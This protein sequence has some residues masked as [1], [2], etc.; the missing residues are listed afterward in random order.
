MTNI[1]KV[2]EIVSKYVCMDAVVGMDA[3]R[4]LV[5]FCCKKMAEWKDEQHCDE[6]T[7]LK[8]KVDN[9]EQMLKQT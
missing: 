8:E 7:F 9:I 3:V 2:E 4:E 5:S 1:E 6:L